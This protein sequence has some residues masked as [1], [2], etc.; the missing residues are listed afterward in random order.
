[1]AAI[2][3]R[4]DGLLVHASTVAMEAALLAISREVSPGRLTLKQWLA[5]V[6]RRPAPFM[7]FDVRGLPPAKEEGGHCYFWR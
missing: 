1:M 6:A 5:D 7:D 3:I 4:Q 2:V